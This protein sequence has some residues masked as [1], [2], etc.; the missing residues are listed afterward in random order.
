MAFLKSRERTW[1]GSVQGAVATWSTMEVK[2]HLEISHAVTD[3]VAIAPC[4]DPV[5]VHSVTFEAKPLDDITDPLED[6]FARYLLSLRTEGGPFY[7]GCVPEGARSIAS[8]L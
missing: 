2:N 1:I 6:A 4:T 5:Q 3:Q 7:V 8:Q